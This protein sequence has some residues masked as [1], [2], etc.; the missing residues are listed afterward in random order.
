MIRLFLLILALVAVPLRAQETGGGGA[1][2][3]IGGIPVDTA[4]RN[5]YEARLA[6]YAIARRKAW[7]MLW[8]RLTGMAENSA[9]RLGD[10]ALQAMVAGIEVEGE[11]FSTTRYIAR[12]GVV[13][14]RAR[15]SAYFEGTAGSLHSGPMLLLPIFTDGGTRTLY[16]TKTP[17]IAAWARFSEGLSPI[18]YVL[19]S[20]S[21]GDNVLLTAYQTQRGERSLW[22]NIL[23]RFGSIDVLIAEVRL[24]RSFPGGPVSAEF[25]ARHGPDATELGRLSLRST[26]DGLDAMLDQGVRAIDNIYAQALREGRLV[27]EPDLTAELEPII[28]LAP[29]IAG[30]AFAGGATIEADIVTPDGKAY[31]EIEALLRSVPGVS[32]VTLTSVSLGG[33]SRVAIRYTDTPEM[34]RYQLD[35]KGLRLA[36]TA[37]GVLL[38]RRVTG[39]VPVP[40]PVVIP[41]PI[42]VPGAPVPAGAPATP[43]AGSLPAEAPPATVPQAPVVPPPG[44]RPRERERERDR[45]ERPPPRP[46]APEAGPID[47]L[48]G[49][50][51]R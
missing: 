44:D 23:N 16:Q 15:A 28:S 7:P 25:I 21:A 8:N 3:V 38:R 31:A 11:R 9:P 39:D 45:R 34:L 35:Q 13:F 36:D 17:W 41:P 19:A 22:R 14:D 18:D 29:D 43:P 46:A 2:Y 49:T 5:T 10:G 42:A 33:T 4:A 32:G 40:A 12:L 50:Q 47:L 30:P 1:A 48:D 24:V 20:G 37:T 6:A 27:S 51:P 26:T